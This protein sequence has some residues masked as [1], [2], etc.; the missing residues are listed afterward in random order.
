MTLRGNAKD[1]AEAVVSS[2]K[3]VFG[4]STERKK[5]LSNYWNRIPPE[6]GV[7]PSRKKRSKSSSPHKSAKT[8]PFA[9]LGSEAKDEA[10]RGKR[11]K[12][13][14]KKRDKKRR[15]SGAR[16]SE[17]D[18]SDISPKSGERFSA[19]NMLSS[20]ASAILQ[21]QTIENEPKEQNRMLPVLN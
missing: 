6:V 19:M 18:S 17:S 13:D 5:F 16:G 2:L 12:K 3:K 4:D 14:K 7:S 9:G 11:G 10:K 20:L 8:D 1:Q 15:S 21:D